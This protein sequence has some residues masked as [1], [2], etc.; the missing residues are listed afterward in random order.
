MY[1]NVVCVL[2]TTND[3]QTNKK[4]KRERDRNQEVVGARH[5]PNH[6]PTPISSL[7]F[8]FFGRQRTINEQQHNPKLKCNKLG[9][10]HQQ[11]RSP[12]AHPTAECWMM[13]TIERKGPFLAHST[14]LH[15]TPANERE[16]GN[17]QKISLPRFFII[18]L[19]CFAFASHWL[20]HR[21]ASGWY[22]RRTRHYYYFFF[23]NNKTI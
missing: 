22:N 13:V 3:K 2:R 1:I 4:A 18:I 8:Y 12:T 20:V 17:Q 10:K 21:V 14:I 16:T 6:P 5:T 23:P 7:L 19:L 11:E 15:S 9:D